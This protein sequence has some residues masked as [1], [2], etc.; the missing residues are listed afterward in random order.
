[1]SEITPERR[2][3]AIHYLAG[4]DEELAYAVAHVAR[5]EYIA[6]KKRQLIFLHST[7]KT[8]AERQAEA[9][10]HPEVVEA[11]DTHFEALRHREH[12]RN[13]RKT[14]ELVWETWRS[15]NSNR[16]HGAP[17]S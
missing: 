13:K 17:A 3:Q 9:D 1:M 7:A 2:D 16:R 11:M 6:K 15:E 14:E 12:L 5:T 4:T 10:T 8:V